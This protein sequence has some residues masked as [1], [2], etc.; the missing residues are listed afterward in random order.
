MENYSKRPLRAERTH[1]INQ[2]AAKHLNSAF[3]ASRLV[4]ITADGIEVYLRDRLRQRIRIKSSLGFREGNVLQPAT[5]HQEFRALRRMLNVAVRKKLLPANPG[6]GLEF[7]G[8]VKGMFRPHYVSWSEQ[9]GIEQRAQTQLMNIVRISRR[10]VCGFTR[11]LCCRFSKRRDPFL[12]C[13]SKPI[14]PFK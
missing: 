2:R 11:N 10:Q 6:A 12:S 7:P 9:K 4:D 1:E 5:V 8:R 14:P 13:F 3:A